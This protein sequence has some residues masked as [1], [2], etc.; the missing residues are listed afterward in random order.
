MS[1]R[2][3]LERF[4]AGDIYPASFPHRE[5]VRMA[6]EMLRVHDFP[7]SVLNYSR[8]LQRLTA[9]AGRPAVFNQTITVA[10]L[11]LVAE[12]MQAAPC[13]DFAAFAAA[14]PELLDRS[15]L[16][17]WYPKARLASE[18]ARRVFLLPESPR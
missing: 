7:E 2:A 8:A 1:E 3:D 6:F 15:I 16:D 18:A 14:H 10:F 5:H 9:R 4:M 11:S 12:R 13:S 17:R